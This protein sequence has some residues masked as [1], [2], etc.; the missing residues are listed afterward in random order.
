MYILTIN[1]HGLIRSENIEFG[2]DADTGGQT[3]YV[4]DL[5]KNISTYPEISRIDLATRLIR[6]KTVSADYS[7]EIER[8]N[9][10]SRIVRFGCGSGKYLHKEKLW[11]HLDEFTDKI[12]SY[13]SKQKK[14]PDLVYGHYA[15]AGYVSMQIASIFGIPFVFAGHSLGHNKLSF[16]LENGWS[17]KRADKEFALETRIRNEEEIMLNTDLVVASTEYEKEKLYG[18]YANSDAPDYVI[19]PPGLDLEQF[20]PYYNYEMP[21]DIIPE[22]QK[23]AQHRISN[24][25]KRFHFNSDKPLILSLCR[26]DARKNIDV[27][28]D[29][30]G[31]DKELQSMANLAI[32]AGIRGDINDMPE[33][34]QQVLTDILLQMDKYD[35][36]GKLAIPKNHDPSTE[37]PEL[38]RI[39]ALKKG[40]FVSASYLE[41]FGLTFVEASAAGLPFV[42]TNQGGPVDIVNNCESGVL[43][44]ISNPDEVGAKIKEILSDD[45][46]W[47]ELSDKGINNTR[48]VYT[49][50]HHCEKLIHEF[51]QLINKKANDIFKIDPSMLTIG[52]R[53]DAISH[54]LIVD[55]DDTLIGEK[56]SLDLLIEYIKENKSWLGFGVATGRNIESAL[57]ILE[58]HGVPYPDIA[59]TSVGTEIYY[60]GK[61]QDKG[62]ITHIKK[63]WRPERVCQALEKNPYITVQKLPEAQRE[64]K[65]SYDFD[66]SCDPAQAIPDIHAVLAARKLKYSLIFSHGSY[67]DILPYRA[68]K[69]KAIRYL[70]NKWK[71]PAERIMTAG[72]SG[73]D[74]D[75]L[76]G[77]LNGIVVANHESDLES[78]KRTSHIYFAQ[79]PYAGGILE[80][81]R[82]FL[83][84]IKKEV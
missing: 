57:M 12:I 9:D 55:I 23:Q 1:I 32:F 78:L 28:I 59:I 81:M 66:R 25:M 83:K 60:Q 20:F 18:M 52:K 47:T 40:V 29:I 67:V 51:N 36:Y 73:N 53:L 11:P 17:R 19:I 62:W 79:E 38:Y 56:A 30:Y 48:A 45:E 31:R 3:R 27:L 43:V 5:V 70:S 72:N 58:A 84:K 54:L 41:T 16:L 14:I 7:R 61:L 10:K 2:R 37:V 35:L 77:N 21:G 24:E 69:G 4:I 74:Y 42:A 82:H 13:I 65:K 49:W 44:D 46:L 71:I 80:G 6:D 64:F 39:A 76:T 75:M 33:A 68:A 63:D 8:I 50:Q 26:P 15:D 22:V 34:E